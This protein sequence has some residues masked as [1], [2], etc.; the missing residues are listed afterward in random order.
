MY[1]PVPSNNDDAFHW[2]FVQRASEA[3]ANG[4]NPLDFWTP[5]LELGFPAFV[6]YQHLPHIA[7]VVLH[8]AMFGL[9]PLLGVFNL[10]RYLLMALLPLT[11]LWSMRRMDLSWPA[12]AFAA[13]AAPLI[14]TPFLFGFDYESYVWRGF[15]TYTQLWAMHLSFVAVATVYQVLA[16]R[17]GH[18]LAIVALAALVL[19][20]LLY[21]YMA[22]IS[23]GVLFLALLRRARWRT[24]VRDLAIVGAAS[25]LVTS[26][27]WLPYLQLDA[28]LNLSPYLQP[29]KYDGLGAPAVLRS[30]FSGQLFDNGRLPV[31]TVLVGLG[32]VVAVRTRTRLT[33]AMLALFVVWLVLYFGRPTFG[34]L[35]DLLPLSKSLFIHRF[36]GAVHLAGIM[37]IGVGAGWLW[38]LQLRT[39][40]LWVPYAAG[41]VA[42]LALVPLIGE[43]AAFY[44]QGLGWMRVTQAAIASDADATAIVDTLRGLPRGRTFAGLRTDYGPRMNFG[45]PFNSVRFSDLLVFDGLDVLSPPYNSLSLSS[46]L[47]WDF[48]YQRAEDYDLF[49]VRYV[50]MPSGLAAPSFLQPIRATS[51]YG[52][53]AAP[54]TGYGEWVRVGE[55]RAASGSHEL[56]AGDRPWLLASDR[57]TRGFIRWDYPAAGTLDAPLPPACARG[58][59]RDDVVRAARI[60]VVASCDTGGTLLLKVTYDPGWVVTVDGAPAKTFMLSPAYLGVL[61]PAGTHVVRAA[62]ESVPL[63]TP[64]LV[65]GALALVAAVPVTRR[66]R[67]F[68]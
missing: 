64:L 2:L 13:C 29:E 60:E 1:L 30:L 15:G 41:A 17:R 20:H 46:D 38:E 47:L 53:Y 34:A 3:L 55:R 65:L 14:S 61:V 4:E 42:V 9:V 32:A 62:Y 27:F 39:W 21:A 6:H 50:V 22:A 8:R 52:L 35:Y 33:L 67:H 56:I 58:T 25:L 18:L 26:Y 51:R 37:L 36:S 12:A 16:H 40:R 43:R 5:Q 59:V 49:D 19:S 24:Q 48:N 57:A 10:V 68:A 31:L 45:I 63:K 28:Y 54:T 44:D 11:V 7:V 66:L 23:I